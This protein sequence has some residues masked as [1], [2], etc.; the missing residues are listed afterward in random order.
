DHFDS[1]EFYDWVGE[2]GEEKA[3]DQHGRARAALQV[4]S[5]TAETTIKVARAYGGEVPMPWGGDLAGRHHGHFG[6]TIVS[7]APGDLRPRA[8]GVVLSSREGRVEIPVEPVKAFP[9]KFGVIDELINALARG[10]PPLHDGRWGKATLEVC[11][12]IL[13]SARERRE[14][15]LTC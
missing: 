7:W 2:A 15:M 9:D 1:D 8:E 10:R 5:G 4:G 3:R 13:T 6:V 11:Q 12:A 14:V